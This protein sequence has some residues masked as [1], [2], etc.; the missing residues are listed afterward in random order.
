MS[1]SVKL[2]FDVIM[3]LQGS[4][5]SALT[6]GRLKQASVSARAVAV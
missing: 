4:S 1:T 6:N 3:L 2:W 5:D